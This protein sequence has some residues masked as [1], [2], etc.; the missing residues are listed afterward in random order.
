[1]KKNL[2]TEQQAEAAMQSLEGLSP[3][4][5]NPYL[6]TRIQQRM[7]NKKTAYTYGNMMFR[8]AIIL[9]LF[10]AA[11]LFTYEKIT[12]EPGEGNNNSSIES[13][14]SDYELSESREN[15]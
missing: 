2:L 5:A 9:L 4:S 1:M 6:F 13:F 3:A 7:L 8:L 10:I 11:N 15:I 14:A 12:G